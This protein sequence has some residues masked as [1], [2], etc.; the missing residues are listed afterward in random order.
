MSPLALRKA[1]P[2]TP[3]NIIKVAVKTCSKAELELLKRKAAGTS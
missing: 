2:D 1:I 3:Q